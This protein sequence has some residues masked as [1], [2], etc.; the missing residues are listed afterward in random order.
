M[1]ALSEASTPAQDAAPPSIEQL[2]QHN[3]QLAAD[4]HQQSA[5]SA[6]QNADGS[7]KRASSP[8]SPPSS[9]V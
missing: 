8:P 3:P 1:S 9:P 2:Q 6:A 7:R 5:S 4:L